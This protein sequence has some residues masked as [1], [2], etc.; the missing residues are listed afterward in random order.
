MSD[1]ETQ[2]LRQSLTALEARVSAIEN[3]MMQTLREISER[4]QGA[5]DPVTQLIVGALA[6]VS[7]DP[8]NTSSWEKMRDILKATQKKYPSVAPAPDVPRDP[9]QS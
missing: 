1:Q 6:I 9:S 2:A 4:L 7:R 8:F 3:E 5:S